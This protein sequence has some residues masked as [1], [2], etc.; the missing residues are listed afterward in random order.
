M[1][2]RWKITI[3][4]DGNDFVGWQAQN[5]GTSVQQVIEEAVYTLSGERL[6]LQVAGRTDAGVHALGQV[7]HFDLQHEYNDHEIRNALNF[8]MRPHAVSIVKAEAMTKDFH[9]RFGAERR[10]YRYAMMNRPAPPVIGR[11][12]MWHIPKPL[13]VAA[14]QQAAKHFVGHHDFTSFRAS[15]CQAKSPIRTLDVLEISTEGD[16]IY[17]DLNARSFL[18]HQVRNLVGTLRRVGDRSWH[19]DVIPEILA[20]KDRSKAGPTA[21][22]YGLFFIKVDYDPT[23]KSAGTDVQSKAVSTDLPG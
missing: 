14:M 21:P 17:F 16:M 12:Y 6:R 2:Q 22:A 7:A 15:E 20:A 11:Q 4:Y 18:H 9:A 8:H 3:E 5:N 1:T 23:F 10:Y 19:P 13:D